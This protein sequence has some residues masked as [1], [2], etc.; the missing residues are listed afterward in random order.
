[1]T[2]GPGPPPQ[3]PREEPE[4]PPAS[5]PPS[6]AP[7]QESP[8]QGP[9]PQ[10]PPAESPPADSPRPSD[11]WTQPTP[12]PPPPG[13]PTGP[14][15]PYPP[16]AAPPPSGTGYQYA[17]PATTY[18]SGYTPD[19][20]PPKTNGLAIVSLIFGIAQFVVCPVV[21]WIVAIITGHI[22]LGQIKRNPSREGGKGLA[23]AGTILGYVGAALTV[24][25]IVAGIVV[26][27]VF[28]EDITRATLRSDGR[29][30]INNAKSEA[31]ANN[32][33]LRNAAILQ[34]AYNDTTFEDNTDITLA[35]GTPITV[36]TQDAWERSGW[37]V[38]LHGSL[39]RSADVCM[40]VPSQLNESPHFTDGACSSA[41]A[42]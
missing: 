11:P 19:Y 1:V 33:E 2:D 3:P 12:A 34:R 18:P 41:T 23:R 17:A 9:P 32:T 24:L 7:P 40:T 35:D 14:P 42:D 8:P 15:P 30:W 39:L 13:S 36:A 38:Q 31:A 16:P 20:G 25:A 22:A 27:G 21:G 29:D 26:F 28:G 10:G 37:R 5:P 4:S 6:D